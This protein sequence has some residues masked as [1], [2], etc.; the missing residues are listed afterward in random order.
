MNYQF[1][2]EKKMVMKNKL[3]KEYIVEILLLLLILVLF[4]Q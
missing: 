4:T 1:G 2:K 3:L